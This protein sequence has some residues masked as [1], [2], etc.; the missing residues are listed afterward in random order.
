[1]FPGWTHRRRFP[2]TG[3]CLSQTR[4]WPLCESKRPTHQHCSSL[5]WCLWVTNVG[6]CDLALSSQLRLWGLLQQHLRMR[7]DTRW[8]QLAV[9]R[10]FGQW[11]SYDKTSP[12]KYHVQ[13]NHI[14][15]V[16]VC[17]TSQ[18][19]YHE[20]WVVASSLNHL[21]FTM[22]KSCFC[23]FYLSNISQSFVEVYNLTSDLSQ[24]VNIVKK[25]DP[26]LLQAM[27]QHLIKLQS[28]AGSSCHDNGINGLCQT[29]TK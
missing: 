13:P 2:S 1:M 16:F 6:I 23:V 14:K 19:A 12:F 28:C 22:N 11:S 18:L 27:N 25:V 15:L 3:P 10:V 21:Y 8:N 4:L 7:Q 17:L 29:T 26:A 9:L 24:L 5:Y 20:L